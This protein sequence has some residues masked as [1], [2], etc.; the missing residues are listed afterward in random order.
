MLCAS[1][2]FTVINANSSTNN[3]SLS[4]DDYCKYLTQVPTARKYW[5]KIAVL[6]GYL[7]GTDYR[8]GF[9]D[10][11]CGIEGG[12]H[13]AWL[14]IQAI[15]K[16]T[17]G[18]KY[19]KP[20]DWSAKHA[21]PKINRS[22]GST[23]LGTMVAEQDRNTGAITEVLC[24]LTVPLL[25]QDN[26]DWVNAINRE[27]NCII[28]NMSA[29]H[30]DSKDGNPANK[31]SAGNIRVFG[32]VHLPNKRFNA[33]ADIV[34]RRVDY[35]FP[36]DILLPPTS[37]VSET[38][39]SPDKSFSVQEFLD[40]FQSFPPGNKS[41][42]VIDISEKGKHN[43]RDQAIFFK[44]E[45]MPAFIRP[46]ENTLK[47]LARL[48]K[49]MQKFQTQV[50]ILN[51]DD[52]GAMLEKS[53]NETKRKNQT[54][55][56]KRNR[57]DGQKS[58]TYADPD[59][60]DETKEVQS[61]KEDDSDAEENGDE[62]MIDKTATNVKRLLR[63]KRYHNFSPNIL[64]HDYMAYRRVDRF[65]HRGTIRL[66][67][68]TDTV[69]CKMVRPFFVFAFKGDVI[70]H[71]QVV[72]VMGL[73]I[74]ICRGIINEAILECIF[75]EDFTHLIPAPPAPSI[76]L[77]AGDSSYITWEGRIKTILTARPSNRFLKG[78]NDEEIIE[79]V[80]AWEDEMLRDV[81]KVSCP[82]YVISRSFCIYRACSYLP[83]L[84]SSLGLV[85]GWSKR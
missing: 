74:A 59:V 39:L 51:L 11:P 45:A 64:A 29:G 79:N 25:R 4:P 83:I 47:Y 19:E 85:L 72:R 30:T 58:A 40:T 14:V 1:H 68:D 54:S 43:G 12:Q 62:D 80:I 7:P 37:K 48:K 63:R 20:T 15:E 71:E 61:A 36:A 73:L 17:Q 6:Y 81:A 57:V 76:G 16:V 42:R 28:H 5:E 8:F 65:Y 27:L 55:Q 35:C 82:H 70:L 75:D 53:M 50:E 26:K 67:E 78:W 32:R 3:K 9:N 44:N 33:E 24:T 69:T 34:H 21:D 49:L 46:N 84:S 41:Y 60:I 66:D 18:E 10:N 31:W 38:A 77:L 2:I 52:K 22:Y 56:K 23:S 13:A